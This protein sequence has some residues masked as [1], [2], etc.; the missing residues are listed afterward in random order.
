MKKFYKFMPLLLILIL[1]FTGTLF[2]TIVWG[3]D[4]TP[5]IGITAE[6]EH[7]N[8]CVDCHRKVNEGSDY[9][10]NVELSHIEKHPKIEKIVATVP[11]DCLKCHKKDTDAGP[12]NLIIHKNHYE[13]PNEN[14]FVS[15]Y[16]GNCLQCHSLDMNSWKMGLKS[17]PANW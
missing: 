9:R 3:A 4:G 16:K 10:L 11:N 1:I 15:S 5:L 2:I 14:H 8:G 6:D 13:N 17:G 7:P 12:L